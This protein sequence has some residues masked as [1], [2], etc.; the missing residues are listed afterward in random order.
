LHGSAEGHVGCVEHPVHFRRQSEYVPV[1][2]F[3][4]DV[5]AADEA[6]SAV[7]DRLRRA[8]AEKLTLLVRRRLGSA[9]DALGDDVRRRGQPVGGTPAV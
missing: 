8:D 3:R 2:R 6:H 9:V 1:I 4:E 7:A 5:V